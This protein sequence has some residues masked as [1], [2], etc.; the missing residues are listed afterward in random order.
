MIVSIAA[1]ALP[2]SAGAV[3]RTFSVLPN[4]PTTQS[5][6]DAGMALTCSL[7]VASPIRR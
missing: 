6:E 5:R 3:T 2:R 1:L 7:I 4:H